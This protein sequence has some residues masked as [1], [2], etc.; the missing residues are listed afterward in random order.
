MSVIEKKPT[1][2]KIGDNT[3]KEKKVDDASSDEKKRSDNGIKKRKELLERLIE[4]APSMIIGTNLLGKI[5][6][7][8]E[9]AEM[10]TGYN[11]KE[12]VGKNLIT[13]LI[14]E[15]Q[16][17]E[18]AALFEKPKQ[19]ISIFNSERH[20]IN[21]NGDKRLISW[22]G[23]PL[24]DS[25][26]RMIGEI[27]IGNDIT[28]KSIMVNEVI[29][30]NKELS[31]INSVGLS[32]LQSSDLDTILKT[33]LKRA[34]KLLNPAGGAVYILDER[35][36]R[37]VLR[38]YEKISPETAEAFSSFELGHGIP[39][40]AAKAKH[41][42]L[43]KNLLL[44]SDRTRGILEKERFSSMAFIPIRT[45]RGVVGVLAVGAKNSQK[46]SPK[47]IKVF[48]TISNQIGIIVDNMRLVKELSMVGREWENTFN[49]I[50]DP[51]LLISKGN[52]I[53]WVNIAYARMMSSI[54][55]ELIGKSCCDI[56]H[57]AK[58]PLHSCIHK[59][60]FETQV[61]FSDEIYDPN[62]GLTTMVSCSPYKNATGELIGTLVKISDITE[63]KEAE[64][65]VKYLKEFNESIVE[66]L[67][68]GL[69]IIGPDH[70]IQFMN[71]NFY[72]SVGK[73]VIGRTCYEVHFESEAPC[74]DCPITNG[75]ENM[76]IE[77]LECETS[78]GNN[79]MIT[80]SPLK[81]QDGSYSA[82]LL[83]KRI[84]EKKV[85]QKEPTETQ[86][87][88]NI[89]TI[90]SGIAHEVNNP[91]GGVINNAEAI[92]G[93]DDP[94]KI[95]L[96]SKE[97]IDS[98]NRICVLLK[99]M[100]DEPIDPSSPPMVPI[101]L[102]DI[103]IRSLNTL[104]T[105]TKFEDVEVVTDLNPIP[106]IH[107][108][109]VEMLEVFINLISKALE[110]MEGPGKI[111]ISTRI[112]N[113]SIQMVLKDEGAG[114]PKEK[115][116]KIFDPFSTKEKGTGPKMYAI[117]KILKKHNAPINVESEEGKGTSFTINF[118]NV[119]AA[120]KNA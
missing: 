106:R 5:T 107:G 48:T 118:P 22:S 49:S 70:K 95:R 55:E 87:I 51:M 90:V 31:A 9:A 47:E 28:E 102:N 115:L 92:M 46:I 1:L 56:F 16:K 61:G 100:T 101:D 50:S 7:F 80:H 116:D 73:D 72:D 99:G 68:D 12:A 84:T 93:E 3:V 67:G 77:T 75:L 88:P 83:F 18:T 65:E 58:S 120:K 79:F 104:N 10:V 108:N 19:G 54:P 21:K 42:V 76:G 74:E 23:A 40:K 36:K 86:N 4:T 37:L 59:K 43:F 13:L 11:K 66:S 85:L 105:D 25:E 41:H 53:L 97:I 39:G 78:D 26:N 8:N 45:K 27:F 14:P 111:F 57:D 33:V 2:L 35:S 119:H 98:A 69:E 113:G 30:Q 15:D 96:Y 24:G 114:I 64:N 6:I 34:L 62:T 52:K 91:L 103:I 38:A 94:L 117:A 20:I 63:K 110:S 71:K 44:F 81:N 82:I 17:E 60:V 89:T 109:P 32:L 29:R 112:L